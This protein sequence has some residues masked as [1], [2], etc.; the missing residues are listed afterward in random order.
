MLNPGNTNRRDMLRSAVGDWLERIVARTESRVV[1]RHYHRP[2]GALPEMGFLAA[3]TRCG[4]CVDACPPHAITKVPAQGGLAAG[5]PHLDLTVQPCIACATM[6]CAV[7]C[8]TEALTVPLSVWSGYRIAHLEFKPESCLTFAGTSCRL[9]AD[10]CPAGEAALTIDALG[11]PVVRQ[12]G[13]VGCGV[14]ASVCPTHPTSF[15]LSY[16]EH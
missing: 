10:A 2:P 14:C 15:T 16:Q 9:C 7:A 13:C 11:H 5:T 8:P 12:E 1:N 4:A 3:C 6:P